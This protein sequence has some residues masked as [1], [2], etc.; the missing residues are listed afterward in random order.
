MSVVERDTRYDQCTLCGNRGHRSS[1]CTINSQMGT[2]RQLIE[3]LKAFD[4]EMPVFLWDDHET[5]S[6]WTNPIPRVVSKEDADKYWNHALPC[7]KAVI[8]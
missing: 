4:P 7:D 6:G 2:V 1:D 5:C 3:R 8:L